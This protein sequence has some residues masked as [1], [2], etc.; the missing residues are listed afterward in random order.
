MFLTMN[1]EKIIAIKAEF[2]A[3]V[4][5]IKSL[6]DVEQIKIKFLGKKS[7]LVNLLTDLKNISDREAKIRFGR[8]VNNLKS[9]IENTLESKMEA[10]SE[11]QAE[12]RIL[13]NKNFDVT[14]RL[15]DIY[16]P[17]NLHIYSKFYSEVEDLFISMGFQIFSGP[18]VE[19]EFFNFTALNID[20]DHPARDMYDTLWLNKQDYLLRT[21]T[22]SVQIRTMREFGAPLAG[23]S[24][25]RVFRHEAIDAT[26]EVVFSQ[27]EGMLIDKNI[28]LSHLLSI[29]KSVL[30][31]LFNKKDIKIRTRPGFFPFVTPGIEIDMQCVFCKNGCGVCKHSTWIEVFPAGLIHPKVLEYGNIDPNIYSG[32]A[33]GFGI[34]R[35]IMLRHGINDIRLFK[36]GDVN[37]LSK[38]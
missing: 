15:P 13:L 26:H 24:I 34:D 12:H 38:F 3:L 5:N 9:F 20:Q 37:F 17:G 16:L 27:C 14:A 19:H 31:K 10:L 21:H 18:E 8:E 25:G 35:L 36:S 32:F 6:A 28:N 33:F 11:L 22:S 7:E 4:E 1:L 2:E 29:A 23:I 30:Q